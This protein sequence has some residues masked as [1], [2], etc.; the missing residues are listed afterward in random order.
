M[1]PTPRQSKQAP[2]NKPFPSVPEFENAVI[3]ALI[4]ESAAFPRIE[5]ILTDA[6][7]FSQ[8]DNRLIFEAIQIM[9][10]ANENIDILTVKQKLSALGKLNDAGG[11]YCI[12]HKTRNIMSSAHIEYHS[13]IIQQKWMQRQVMLQSIRTL[14]NA[15]DD[16]YD[17]ADVIDNLNT[18]IYNIQSRVFSNQYLPLREVITTT[19]NSINSNMNRGNKLLGIS[20]GFTLLNDITLGFQNSDLVVIAARPAM[21]KTAFVGTISKHIS[22]DH[23]IGCAVFSLEMSAEQLMMRYFSLVSGVNFQNIRSGNFSHDELRNFD[24]SVQVMINSKLI[25]DDTPALSVEEFRNKLKHMVRAEGVKIAFIDYLQLMTAKSS[26]FGTRQE[27]V[28]FIS[29]ALKAVAKELNIPIVALSQLNRETES[30][31]AEGIRPKLSNLRESGAIEQDADI[32]C[33]IHRPEYYGV[34]TETINNKSID[35]T[36]K[37]ELIIAKH[38]NGITGN[39]ILRFNSQIVQFA[40]DIESGPF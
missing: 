18:S 15:S 28:S 13:R 10:Y 5:N 40:D 26:K 8:L 38:R 34:K 2:F 36:G 7:M 31:A 3:G 29:K 11:D 22:V 39:I 4:I 21:G 32:V 9:Y 14:A 19:V 27:E 30:K 6:D 37:A 24:Q 12:F 35:W 1:S 23:H 17:I 25:I 33:F 16:T 20:T